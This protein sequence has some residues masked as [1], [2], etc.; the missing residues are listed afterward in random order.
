MGSDLRIGIIGN[1]LVAAEL[2]AVLDDVAWRPDAP[3]VFGRA[4]TTTTQLSY[5]DAM[6]P[7]DELNVEALAGFDLVFVAVPGAA[8]SAIVSSLAH[9]GVKVVDLSGSAIGD[10]GTPLILPALNMGDLA[11]RRNRDVVSIPSPGG[12]LI[13]SVLAPLVRAGFRGT[14]D[15]TV[16]LPASFWG[17]EGLDELSKQVVALFNA[18]TPPRKVFE[19]G[20]AFDLLPA[21]GEAGPSGWTGHEL[22]IAAEVARITGQRVHATAVAVPVFSGVSATITLD[23][24][25][26]PPTEHLA[27]IWREADVTLVEGRKLPRPRRTEGVSGVQVARVREAGD[28]RLTVWATTDNLRTAAVAAVTVAEVWLGLVESVH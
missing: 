18:G 9:L 13:A 24:E 16:M 4:S 27:G 25:G 23:G 20:L 14:A 15:A 28:D 8:A 11:G 3:A 22:R 1:G 21:V 6:V 2:L 26:L 5:G 10:M 12:L 19:H 17:R 7:V